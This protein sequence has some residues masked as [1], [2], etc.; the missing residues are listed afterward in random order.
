MMAESVEAPARE[1]GSRA[2]LD[3]A[4]RDP[5][6]RWTT[7]AVASALVL[8]LVWVGFAGHH[9][10]LGLFDPARYVGFAGEI[11]QGK[12]YVDFFTGQPTSY[13]PP[14]YPWFLG[15]IAWL[16]VHGPFGNFLPLAAGLIQAVLGALTA[17]FAAIV[18]RRLVSPRAG[19]LAAIGIAIYPNLVFHTGAMLSETLYNFLFLAFLAV[20]LER[21]WPAGLSNQRIT[22]AAV[23]YGLAVLVR[24]IS[25]VIVPVLLIVWYMSTRSWS[26]ALR[27]T[28]LTVG[29]VVALILPWT[30]R[31][32]VR[33][34]AFVALSTNTGDNLCIG[35]HPG[36]NGAFALA[37]AC[38]SGEGV[39]FGTRSEIRNDQV[40]TR[41]TLRYIAHHVGREPWLVTQ[42]AYYMFERDDD[43]LRAVQSYGMD[44]WISAKATLWL[45]RLANTFYA[46]VAILG[47]IGLI[48]LALSRR[49]DRLLLVL[50]ALATVAVPLAFFGDSRFKVP[51][52]PLLVIAA[53]AALSRF[54]PPANEVSTAASAG[55]SGV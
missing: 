47:L 19:I 24:P 28:G 34:H 39:Q 21:P 35:H 46:V 16:Q 2:R 23:L 48:R 52:M 30:I 17:A 54:E 22:A 44:P 38:N 6:W 3:H 55:E 27:W 51:A 18:G 7:V 14:G 37:E 49:P 43:A 42:R 31:N 13:Y 12:G 4:I 11:A 36:A 53:A 45:S 33:M 32:E 40:K 20:L 29:I 10:P 9:K 15:V 1:R 5:F 41:K 26:R 8:R 25:L 50:S